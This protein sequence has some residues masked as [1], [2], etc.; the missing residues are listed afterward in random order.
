MSMAR[1]IFFA[2]LVRL[3]FI[4]FPYELKKKILYFGVAFICKEEGV[5]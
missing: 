2:L 5:H 3:E 1:Q 4:N